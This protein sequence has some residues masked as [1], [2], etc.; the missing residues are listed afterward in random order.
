MRSALFPLC[1]ALFLSVSLRKVWSQPKYSDDCPNSSRK[2]QFSRA[3]VFT[4]HN[5]WRSW[6]PRQR[7]PIMPTPYQHHRQQK[8]PCSSLRQVGSSPFDPWAK[9]R[10]D[11]RFWIT[12]SPLI[13]LGWISPPL[14]LNKAS[15]VWRKKGDFVSGKAKTRLSNKKVRTTDLFNRRDVLYVDYLIDHRQWTQ[16]KILNE[17]RWAYRRKR[18]DL[19]VREIIL[20]QDNSHTKIGVTRLK[21]TWGPSI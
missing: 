3:Q 4:R 12:I 18:G 13:K 21:N 9:I 16:N 14:S 15:K 20:L 5:S 17:V 7:E 1:S 6:A 19:S 2:R 11:T 10:R 8:S